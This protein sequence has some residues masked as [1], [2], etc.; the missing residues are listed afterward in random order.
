MKTITR[1]NG[2]RGEVCVENFQVWIKDVHGKIEKKEKADFY[3]LTGDHRVHGSRIMGS[4]YDNQ[5]QKDLRDP[6]G[7]EVQN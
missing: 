4:S 6:K 3:W 7:L 1:R 2:V 5:N